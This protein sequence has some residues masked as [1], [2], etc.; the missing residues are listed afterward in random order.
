MGRSG[1]G[2]GGG[3]RSGGGFSSGG[4]SGGGF[5][6][7]RGGGFGSN[8]SGGG[9]GGF[10]GGNRRG[11]SFGGFGGFGLGG[12]RP[13]DPNPFDNV[14]GGYRP[15]GAPPPPPVFG[16]RRPRPA[17]CSISS[18]LGL[19]IVFA[20]IAVILIFTGFFSMF[21]GGD[22]GGSVDVTAS[23]V[24]REALDRSLAKDTGYYTDKLG[25]ISNKTKMISGM[26]YF[27]EKTGVRP[28]VYLTDTVDGTHTPSASQLEAFSNSQ[29]D[30]LFTDEAHML[31]VFL[32]YDGDYNGWYVCGNQ[33]QTV[34]D[35]EAANILFDY[36]SR[37]LRSESL[38]YEEFFSV[39]F[40]DAADRIM[41]VTTSPW[42]PV[43]I[44]LGVLAVIIVIFVWWRHAKKQKAI[45][46]QQDKEILETPLE[47]FGD[48]EAEQVANK[49]DDDPNT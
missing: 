8:R 19:L 33:A 42:I 35:D 24:A 27:Y 20:V 12:R 18:I 49:Y 22:V 43:L 28:Y 39:S 14:H 21:G 16:Y 34:I 37:N 47:K 9:F 4:R 23:T 48:T 46:A 45:K 36:F 17:G 26:K 31:V 29:Y 30:A 2:F 40:R 44:V 11:S 38:T 32:W 1:G 15:M 10:G 41:T 25:L 5:G 13:V 3:G 6:S 7:N